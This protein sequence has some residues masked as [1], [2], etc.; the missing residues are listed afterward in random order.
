MIS[1][2]F[3]F[4]LMI[5]RPTRSNRTATLFPDTTLFRSAEIDPEA[6]RAVQ[7][8]P[9]RMIG[10]VGPARFDELARDSAFVGRVEHAA[11]GLRAYLA[12]PS[13]WSRN[14]EDPLGSIAYFSP[15]FGVTSVLPQYSGGLGILAGDHLKTASDLG[16]PIIGV[17]LLYKHGYFQQTLSRDGWQEETYPVLA[18]DTAPLSLLREADGTASTISLAVPGEAPR[19]AQ[20]EGPP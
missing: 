15:E 18:T 10:A 4:F 13:W 7:R 9:V 16:I 17:G 1:V 12:E 6:W 2:I 5:R 8:D 3:F 20:S 14:V 19:A 11:A